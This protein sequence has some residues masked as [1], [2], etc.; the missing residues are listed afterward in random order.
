MAISGF[1]MGS[2][3]ITYLLPLESRILK[4][5]EIPWVLAAVIL[6]LPSIEG[7]FSSPG[8]LS[9]SLML[10]GREPMRLVNHELSGTS[11]RVL[12]AC[13]GMNPA[14][15]PFFPLRLP[16]PRFGKRIV[17]QIVVVV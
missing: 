8:P 1:E 16:F 7:P 14:L 11:P 6:H 4:P 15:P 2:N 13:A 10:M 9:S 5:G 12:T 17:E 3:F